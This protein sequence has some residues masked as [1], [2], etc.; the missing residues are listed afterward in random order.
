MTEAY[1]GMGKG[2]DGQCDGT[3]GPPRDTGKTWYQIIR[4]A[5]KYSLIATFATAVAWFVYIT[6]A[7]IR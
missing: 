5:I 2:N 7:A 4:D 3:A 1:K 6:V